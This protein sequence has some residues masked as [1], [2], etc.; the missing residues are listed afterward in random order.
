MFDCR[1]CLVVGVVCC[2]M[3]LVAHCLC[4][5][6]CVLFVVCGFVF[7]VCCSLLAV[8]CVLLVSCLF[9]VVLRLLHIDACVL[10]LYVVSCCL[11]LFVAICCLRVVG[12][13]ALCGICRVLSSNSYWCVLFV[14]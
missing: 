14:A 8:W 4:I 13:C 10:C 6:C 2:R 9:V 5:V 7:A 3:L 12:M 1:S 11:L